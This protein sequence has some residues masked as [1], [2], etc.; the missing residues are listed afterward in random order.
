[1][2][3]RITLMALSVSEGR[4]GEMAGFTTKEVGGRRLLRA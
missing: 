4:R 2:V 1:M 3:N